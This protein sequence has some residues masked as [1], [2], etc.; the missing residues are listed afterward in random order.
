[1][2]T[3]I[4]LVTLL[5][6][7]GPV[8]WAQEEIPVNVENYSFELPGTVKCKNWDGETTY[9]DVPGW[10]DGDATAGDSGVEQPTV[11]GTSDG[12]WIGYIRAADEPVYR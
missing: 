6:M 8:A 5:C 1:M 9:P 7:L 12:T 2:K 10:T 11:G 4:V 3:K